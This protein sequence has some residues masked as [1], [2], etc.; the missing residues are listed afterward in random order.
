MNIVFLTDESG[1]LALSDETW[2]KRYLGFENK[3]VLVSLPDFMVFWGIIFVLVTIG[4]W[5]CKS[6]QPISPEDEPP[7]LVATYREVIAICSLRNVQYLCLLL[8]TCKV[9][10]SPA[11]SV[12]SLKLQEYGLPKADIATI[13][14]LLLLVGLILPALIS[15]KV[16]KNPLEIF[17]YG[18]P[19]KLLTTGLSWVAFQALA[20][21][22][23]SS[24]S[25]V[26]YVFL[27]A[28]MV[29][30]EIAG[31]LIFLSL[32][33]FFNIVS[34]P[35]MGGTYMTLLNTV[36]NLGAKWPNLSVL[37][38][39]PKLTYSDCVIP[40][41]GEVLFSR[42][43]S[44]KTRCASSGGECKTTLDGFTVETG[45]C[46]VFGLLW[47]LICSSTIKHLQTR[48]HEDWSSTKSAK[49]KA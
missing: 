46:I 28:V 49:A 18:V 3:K 30:H 1:L 23:G 6:E 48:R 41:T 20:Q 32:M 5:V 2:C 27:V 37:W 7:G 11:E 38:L 29:L 8:L 44:D 42:C 45:A 12:F 25:F 43:L 19:L 17:M 34:D 40:G 16:S 24:P 22:Q 31:T 9:A 47:L 14:P 21:L 15:S 13:S 26:F 10:F 4:V 39:L 36:S 35:V 33:S